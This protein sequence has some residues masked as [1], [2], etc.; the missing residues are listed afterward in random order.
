MGGN[1]DYQD[2]WIGMPNNEA[3]RRQPPPGEVGG[4]KLWSH[5]YWTRVELSR[6]PVKTLAD[7]I[8][9]ADSYP[10]EMQFVDV[11]IGQ[12]VELEFATSATKILGPKGTPGT[13]KLLWGGFCAFHSVKSN[14]TK[15][16][17][18][19]ECKSQMKS[20]MKTWEEF[21]KWRLLEWNAITKPRGLLK[22]S[23]S[24]GTIWKEH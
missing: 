10:R 23:R 2:N 16:Q 18:P 12:D 6:R 24:N 5:S 3:R 14:D 15:K 21:L 4:A 20:L 17:E 22:R 9:F 11:L 19:W 1:R 7:Q 8:K 13:I